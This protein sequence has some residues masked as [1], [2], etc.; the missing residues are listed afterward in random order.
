MEEIK[1]INNWESYSFYV[2]DK[3]LEPDT[4]NKLNIRFPD[5]YT[6]IVSIKWK[7]VTNSYSDHGH[8]NNVTSTIPYFQL[9]YHGIIV[10]YELN[11]SLSAQITP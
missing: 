4:T 7:K 11:D 9:K 2:G 3:Q 1:V 10:D 5:G 6:K 8:H